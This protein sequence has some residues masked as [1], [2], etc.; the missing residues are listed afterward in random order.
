MDR[1]EPAPFGSLRWYDE[2]PLLEGLRGRRHDL[3]LIDGPPAGTGSM[4]R[5]PALPFLRD[6]GLLAE[7][8]SVFLDDVHRPAERAIVRRWSERYGMTFQLLH[9]RVGYSVP[10][11]RFAALVD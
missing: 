10:P 8:A 9:G 5:Y 1:T 2:R 3:V 7:D 11:G 6:R 4:N